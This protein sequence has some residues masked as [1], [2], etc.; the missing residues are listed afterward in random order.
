MSGNTALRQ[1][2]DAAS[3]NAESPSM[4]TPPR[5]RKN[6]QALR[7]FQD[8]IIN[9][10]WGKATLLETIATTA[11]PLALSSPVLQ[12]LDNAV[13]QLELAYRL[14]KKHEDEG[15]GDGK[16]VEDTENKAWK[17]KVQEEFQRAE[18][19]SLEFLGSR[20]GEEKNIR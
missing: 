19:C 10:S 1:N 15:S 5:H 16:E 20:E 4:K 12:L 13:E 3:T 18:H 17:Q 8:L 11:Y 7:Q 2:G 9:I 14:F 6:S